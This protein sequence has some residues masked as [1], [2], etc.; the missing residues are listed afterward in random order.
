MCH[1][2]KLSEVKM[3]IY[4][5][6][7][8]AQ[9]AG[10]SVA[11]VSR[12]LNDR[13][14]VNAAT[15]EKVNRVIKDCHFVGNASARSLKQ[16]DGDTI[17]IILRGRSNPFLNSVVESLLHYG[18]DRKATFIT[19]YIDER[20]DEFQTAVQL[21]R[22]RR[23]SGFVFLGGSIDSRAKVLSKLDCPMVFVTATAE[24]TPLSRVSSVCVDDRTAAA[25]AVR[26]L[27]DRGHRKIAVF[28]GRPIG[29]DSMAHR[30]QGAVDA[31]L[32]K[33]LTFDES[34][35]VETRFSHSGGY[36]AARA[37]FS[38]KSDT[39]AVFCMSDS[40]AMGVMRALSDLGLKVPEDVSIV[41]FD[42]L[43]IGNYTQPRL[44][45]IEQP[46]DELARQSINVLMD[47]LENAQPPRHLKLDGHLRIRESVR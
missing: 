36:D 38:V 45:T 37:F 29:S 47:M 34:R 21:S 23:M 22:T 10:V 12:V 26:L 18:H 46:V 14:D 31:F 13:P 39:T 2:H 5:I 27:L 41:G 44:T 6:R 42:G 16:T 32:E 19:E 24:D 28:G 35:Y 1:L 20:D 8:I 4:T 25:T 17:A 9:M 43:D 11:T 40:M 30:Y 7:D 15:R 3:K 33:G